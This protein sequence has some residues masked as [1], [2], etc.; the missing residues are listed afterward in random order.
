MGLGLKRGFVWERGG[1]D[2]ETG[3]TSIMV[4]PLRNPAQPCENCDVLWGSYNRLL[5]K[6][7]LIIPV[8]GMLICSLSGSS[9]GRS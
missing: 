6:Q 3:I 8:D 7:L 4:S 1:G 2:S 5:S 9:C